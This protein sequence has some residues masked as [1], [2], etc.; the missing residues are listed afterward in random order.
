M[1]QRHARRLLV[2]DDQ[3]L[4]AT[5]GGNRVIGD[6]AVQ[7]EGTGRPPL[8]ATEEPIDRGHHGFG[9]A[10][11]G[12]QCVALLRGV[13][14]RGDVG[15]DV[16][17]TK[18]VDRLLGVADH[19][20]AGVVLVAVEPLE[21]L[22]LDRV[23]VLELVDQGH[24]ILLA[25]DTG[26]A[27]AV[28]AGQ[29]VAQPGEHVL[30]ADHRLFLLAALDPGAHP[31][32]G[33]QEN[34]RG[35]GR[36]RGFDGAQLGQC[37]QR[38][39]AGDLLD[40]IGATA[41]VVRREPGESGVGEARNLDGICIVRPG[42]DGVEPVGHAGRCRRLLARQALV[43][44]GRF[45]QRQQRGRPLLPLRLHG[46]EALRALRVDIA[47]QAAQVVGGRRRQ[48]GCLVEQGQDAAAQRVR[49]REDGGQRGGGLVA[50]GI[51]AAAP[52]IAYRFLQQ[53]RLVLAQFQL[54]QA[55]RVEG[56]LAQHAVAEGVDGVD[57]GFVHPL[58]GR[59]QAVGAGRM[60][61]GGVVGE[62]AVEKGVMRGC[63]LAPGEAAGGLGQTLA[64]AFA[65]LPRGGL[66]EGD[67]EDLRRQQCPLEGRIAAVLQHQADVQ[68]GEGIGL[69]RAGAGLDQAAAVQRE[70]QGI[71]LAGT[72]ACTS[73]SAW[74][75][76]SG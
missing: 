73:S 59:I 33:V 43:G 36:Q 46:R 45:E 60:F 61:V 8:G 64:D 14:A 20:P 7:L 3:S 5:V 21:G 37:C 62:Q 19:E 71:E 15:E 54:E 67:D 65:Q 72:H 38:W 17:A 52:V 6:A 44:P 16:R 10:E 1:P 57:R 55:A 34:R 32:R 23:G 49:G 26:Q 51:A 53:A 29:C 47:E 40:G 35:V 4:G 12:C 2:I 9:R 39:M 66:G 25:D 63:L 22:V 70:G 42:G 11:I 68:R 27:L 50:E 30:E 69:A 76:T 28:G 41:E 18:T 31:V 56:V 13:V 74:C 24:G 58:R 75:S 48:P